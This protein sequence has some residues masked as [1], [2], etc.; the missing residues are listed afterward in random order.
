LYI[1]DIKKKINKMATKIIILG[2]T[3]IN[4]PLKKIVFNKFLDT[5]DN[6]ESGMC[7]NPHYYKNIELICKEYNEDLEDLMYA[8]DDERNA[9]GLYLGYFNDGVV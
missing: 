7:S 3:Q 2:D 8:Y 6:V 4:S 1:N 5:D 9:G